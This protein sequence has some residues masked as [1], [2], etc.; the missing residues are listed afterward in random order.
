MIGIGS[1]CVTADHYEE[2][3]RSVGAGAA[4]ENLQ[5][6]RSLRDGRHIYSRAMD[7]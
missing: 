3:V 5:V 4:D 7:V 6:F 2:C 1:V